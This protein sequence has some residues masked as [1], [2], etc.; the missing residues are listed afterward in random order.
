MKKNRGCS[1]LVRALNAEAQ[2]AASQIA[3]P[4]YPRIIVISPF[5]S[6][7]ADFEALTTKGDNFYI[8]R[9]DRA[10]KER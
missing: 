4:I 1:K 5:P 3:Q 8:C 7:L 9:E 10:H 2:L 6:S